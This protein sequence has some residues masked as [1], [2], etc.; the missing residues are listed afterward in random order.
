MSIFAREHTATH[1]D[2]E[3][4]FGKKMPEISKEEILSLFPKSL[5]E[6]WGEKESSLRLTVWPEPFSKKKFWWQRLNYIWVLP[7]HC[8]IIGPILWLCTG[9]FGV[10]PSS[11]FGKILCK[12]VGE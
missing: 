3:E 8:L 1:R 6:R 2:I 9:N 12:L 4:V 11:K 7:V 5:W 10:E